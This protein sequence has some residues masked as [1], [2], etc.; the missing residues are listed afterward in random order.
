MS[1]RFSKGYAVGVTR[2][3][4]ILARLHDPY[5]RAYYAGILTERRG[6]ALLHQGSI[7]ADGAAYGFLREAMEHYEQAEKIR[8]PGNDDPLLRWKACA[9]IIS[10]T[11]CPPRPTNASTCRWN[12]PIQAPAVADVQQRMAG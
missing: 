2:A 3:Q 1:D 10:R 4:E 9:R 7:G 11:N 8:P 6:K 12:N 5:E